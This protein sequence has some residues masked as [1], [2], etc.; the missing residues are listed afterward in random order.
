MNIK[1]KTAHH[2][3][4]QEQAIAIE[5]NGI[6]FAVMMMTPQDLSYFAI[7]FLFTEGIID[8]IVD[9]HAVEEH[10][11]SEHSFSNS[12]VSKNTGADHSIERPNIHKE[13]RLYHQTV[14]LQLGLTLKISLANRSF[15]RFKERIR[16]LKGSSG[17]G[18]CGSAALDET[19]KQIKLK[20]SQMIAAQY[21]ICALI[22][23]REKVQQ[24]QTISADSGAMHGAFLI[25]PKGS[26]KA[27][28]E[29]I[30][31]HNALD[32]LIGN[33]LAN[34]IEYQDHAA[35]VTSRCGAELVQKILRIGIKTLISFASPSDLAL[36]LA[37]TANITLIHVPKK[38]API[39]YSPPFI[40]QNDSLENTHT[41]MAIENGEN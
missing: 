25:C 2:S 3:L 26:I 27:S 20:Q 23:I 10:C 30:G 15:F 34:K 11:F 6:A 18:I 38:D 8:T 19:F 41:T 22:D 16:L 13:D 36:Q 12:S 4:A 31:R 17:C 14:G 29:D 32:K 21:D 9:V 24:Y 5:L 39:V 37:N 7:G 35:L 28:C 40:N 1:A 33:I